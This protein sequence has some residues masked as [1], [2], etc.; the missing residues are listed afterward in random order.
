MYRKHRNTWPI[1]RFSYI[2][3]VIN[4]T[5]ILYVLI[6]NCVEL[7]SLFLI[8]QTFFA[9]RVLCKCYKLCMSVELIHE[10]PHFITRSY[11]ML[12][13]FTVLSA[14]S[15]TRKMQIYIFL[16]Y[17]NILFCVTHVILSIMFVFS[18]NTEKNHKKVNR[19]LFFK[20]RNIY[21]TPGITRYI[22]ITQCGR[23]DLFSDNHGW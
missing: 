16:L 7:G 15:A 9:R 12:R 19:S 21:G 8:I 20:E 5:F 4:K 10:E 13:Y 6:M 1:W 18:K 17:R 14:A 3:S 22:L 2:P 23:R 11:L